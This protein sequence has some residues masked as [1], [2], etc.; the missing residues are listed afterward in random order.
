MYREF[1]KNLLWLRS[2]FGIRNPEQVA[3]VVIC[4][5]VAIQGCEAICN[6]IATMIATSVPERFRVAIRVAIRNPE[7]QPEG[8]KI[9]NSGRF[10]WL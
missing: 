1:V 8:P 2:S 4:N 6:P 7:S 9:C 5:L 3:M 10:L